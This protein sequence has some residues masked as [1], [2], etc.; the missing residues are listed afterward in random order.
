MFV[1]R[2]AERHPEHPRGC[3]GDHHRQPDCSPGAM[4]VFWHDIDWQVVRWY[5]PSGVCGA[6]LGGW[7]LVLPVGWLDLLVAVFLLSTAWR[8]RL[9]ERPHSFRMSLPAFVPLSFIVGLLSATIGASGV[10]ASPFYLNR[11]LIK[12]SLLAT[13]A[14]NSLATQL[15]KVGAYAQFGLLSLDLL[16]DGLI[17]G[18]GAGAAVLLSR[19]LL[20]RVDGRRFRQF[21]VVMMV[22][23]GLFILWRRRALLWPL[24]A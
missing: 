20:D 9:G 14:V 6:A 10:V 19:P 11:G 24:L 15:T 21:A 22:V 18:T 1:C 4:A 2:P 7:L 3:A 17:A 23:T 5:V 8:Y 13:R 16:R 12:E